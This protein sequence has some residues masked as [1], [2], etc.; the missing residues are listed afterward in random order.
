MGTTGKLPVF[1]EETARL[2]GRPGMENHGKN[3]GKHG[4]L[5]VPVRRNRRILK[6]LLFIY[7]FIYFN[8]T[9]SYEFVSL[10][11]I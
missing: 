4:V 7:L 9:V 1:P 2:T 5:P 10:A 3:M 11:T 8:R 6:S